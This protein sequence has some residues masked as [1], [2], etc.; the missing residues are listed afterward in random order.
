VLRTRVVYSL[1]FSASR[2]K[3][4]ASGLLHPDQDDSVSFFADPNPILLIL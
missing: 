2:R 3:V 1:F 4:Q